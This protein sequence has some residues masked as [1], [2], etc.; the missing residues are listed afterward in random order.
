MANGTIAF[1]TLTTSDQ[2][3]SGTEKSVDTSYIYN[4]VCKVWINGTL[5]S[6]ANTINQSLNVGSVTDNGT[7]DLTLNFSNSFANANYV[8]M[9][10]GTY[11]NK[12]CDTDIGGDS[13]EN[14]TTFIDCNQY[15]NDPTAGSLGRVDVPYNYGIVGDLA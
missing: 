8:A 9:A 15:N 3:R 4:G 7:G 2:V 11:G 13:T 12:T 10:A 6:G 5:L 1:D 14:T